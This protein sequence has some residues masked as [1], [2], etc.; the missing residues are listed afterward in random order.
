MNSEIPRRPLGSTGEMVSIVGL[1]G[2]HI[3][4]QADEKES[5]AIVRTAIDNGMTFM[6]NCW[7]YN[8]GVSE[9]RMGKALRDG[10]RQRAFLMTKVD[11]RDR[12]TALNQID[13]SL[14]RLQTDVIDLM[15]FHEVI[16]E[17]DPDRIFAPG[18]AIEAFSEAQKAGKIRY[19]GFTGHKSPHLILKMLRVAS[20]NG[21]KFDAVQMPLNIMDAQY[22]S[23]EMG[24]LPALL[25]QNVAVLAMKPIGHAVFLKSHTVTAL[26]CLRYSLSLPVSVVFTGCDSMEI[27]QQAMDAG[28]NFLPLSESERTD[29]LARTVDAASKG[30]FELY[31]TDVIYDATDRNPQWLDKSLKG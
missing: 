14:S 11:G 7:D 3:G 15:Q 28:K 21:F 25:E 19:I 23:F 6:D 12:K 24:V 22:D 2:Y 29:M 8:D 5:I 13:E 26:E 1:G 9:I 27:L 17:S 4:I 16:R 18:G 31:K 20:D 10:Y 30:E